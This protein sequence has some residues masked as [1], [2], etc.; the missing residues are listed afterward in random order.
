M[1]E[2]YPRFCSMKLLKGI[3]TGWDLSPSQ[4]YPQHLKLVDTYLHTC[5]ESYH[6][7]K[8]SC[9]RSQCY[10]HGGLLEPESRVLSI[11]PLHFCKGLI[12]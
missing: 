1:A 4:C 11:R 10:D 12:H 7:N 9:L 2:A 8:V 5:G 3:S 6:E